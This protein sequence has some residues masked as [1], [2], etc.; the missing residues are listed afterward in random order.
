MKSTQSV[1][2]GQT[3]GASAYKPP[4]A[5]NKPTPPQVQ[6]PK[7]VRKLSLRSSAAQIESDI[8]PYPQKTGELKKLGHRVKSWK[9]RFF[10]ISGISI[11]H[12]FFENK[13]S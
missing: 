7:I 13:K 2:N 12:L 1:D 4:Q 8:L 5:Q 3:K 9:R 10:T 11:L 6:P